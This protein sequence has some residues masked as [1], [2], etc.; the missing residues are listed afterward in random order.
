MQIL[1][2]KIRDLRHRRDLT[3]EQ[4]AALVGTTAAH[5]SDV[6]RGRRNPS[7][8]LLAKLAGPLGITAQQLTASD[9]RT[10]LLRIEQVVTQLPAAGEKLASAANMIADFYLRYGTVDAEIVIRPRRKS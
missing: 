8:K 3:L 4:L 2:D 7:P 6:E 5:L 10:H 1:G 9:P